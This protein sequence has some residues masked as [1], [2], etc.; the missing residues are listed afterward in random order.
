MVTLRIFEVTSQTDKPRI[1]TGGNC[2]RKLAF[3]RVII[4]LFSHEAR[5]RQWLSIG[6][7]GQKHFCP[8]RVLNSL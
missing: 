6:S 4:A 3:N 7:V 8:M 2:A 1:F 5:D